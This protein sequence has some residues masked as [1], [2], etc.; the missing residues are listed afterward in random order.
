VW[1]GTDT[2]VLRA[3]DIG[4]LAAELGMPNDLLACLKEDEQWVE[5]G[6]IEYRYSQMSPANYAE[7]VARYG[8]T[9]LHDATT[10]KQTSPYTASMYIALTLSRLA[11]N[12]LLCRHTGTSTG[13]WN[14][15][16]TIS[17][18]ALPPAPAWEQ[19][20]TYEDFARSEGLDP[21]V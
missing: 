1:Q 16:S 21:T 3:D 11:T 19:R 9:R 13:Y 14:Y 5:Y 10:T 8:H 7:L 17:Y 18:W 15:N 6:V 12:G 2:Q 4:G 20:L